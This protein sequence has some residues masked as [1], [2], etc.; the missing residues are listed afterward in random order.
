MRRAGGNV[1][2]DERGE[3]SGRQDS[4]LRGSPIEGTSIPGPQPYR[5]PI[6]RRLPP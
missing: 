1:G 2:A 5:D 4:A 6:R 3:I